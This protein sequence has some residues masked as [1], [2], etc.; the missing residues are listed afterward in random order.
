MI[1]HMISTHEGFRTSVRAA[2]LTSN[3]PVLATCTQPRRWIWPP[4]SRADGARA[5]GRSNASSCSAPM[6]SSSACCWEDTHRWKAGKIWLKNHGRSL[7]RWEIRQELPLVNGKRDGFLMFPVD[8]PFNQS[9]W[10]G[11]E[12]ERL[13]L[14][15]GGSC[16]VE[17]VHMQQV[18]QRF[19]E[20]RA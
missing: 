15:D 3:A 13:E 2:L 18:C 5:I 8:F 7:D 9:R 4:N 17:A 16:A 1:Q 11:L 20:I 12:V 6:R 10:M 14:L 19:F